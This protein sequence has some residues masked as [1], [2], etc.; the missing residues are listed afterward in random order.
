MWF[1]KQGNLPERKVVEEDEAKPITKKKKKNKKA[2]K[3]EELEA[4]VI[5]GEQKVEKGRSP[6]SETRWVCPLCLFCFWGGF[7]FGL[8]VRGEQWRRVACCRK[9]GEREREKNEIVE[10]ALR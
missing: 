7:F 3:V 10:D 9:C 1:G 2:W 6:P 4:I 8:F 5:S